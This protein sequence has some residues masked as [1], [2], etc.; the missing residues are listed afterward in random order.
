M[1]GSIPPL[2]LYAFM[3]FIGTD[4]LYI[5]AYSLESKYLLWEKC[6]ICDQ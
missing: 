4:L 5:F 3:V 1:R 2:S 6:R